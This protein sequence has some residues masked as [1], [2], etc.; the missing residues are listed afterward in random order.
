MLD[1]ASINFMR[2]FMA[3]DDPAMAETKA[4]DHFYRKN[5]PT[6][7]IVST[8]FELK[9]TE[10]NDS[11]ISSSSIVTFALGKKDGSMAIERNTG[12]KLTSDEM[13]RLYPNSTVDSRL[14]VYQ[15][16]TKTMHQILESL[17]LMKDMKELYAFA[18]VD[19]KPETDAILANKG[20]TKYNDK[21]TGGDVWVTE[22][23]KSMSILLLFENHFA[24]V[25]TVFNKVFST[26]KDYVFRL[27][28]QVSIK[29]GPYSKVES[30]RSEDENERYTSKPPKF[31]RDGSWDCL[32]SPDENLTG[33]K[34]RT[35]DVEAIVH[36]IAIEKTETSPKSTGNG[37]TAACARCGKGIF[38]D[39]PEPTQL[40]VTTR[41]DA[42]AQFQA[43]LHR[44]LSDI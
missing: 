15:E 40:Q 21:W 30:L 28:M 3:D 37:F 34:F 20:P 32:R 12:R 43:R 17:T 22:G 35:E 26:S 10:E 7:S 6:D 24:Y 16:A 9:G 14:S 4:E 41:G 13:R 27:E 25:T 36:S 38:Q 42:V 1:P 8:S 39:A 18:L 33:L 2:G 5:Q 11:V 19:D 44:Y 31:G 23:R 29:R